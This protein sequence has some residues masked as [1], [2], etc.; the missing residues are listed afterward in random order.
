MSVITSLL[1][2]SV[3]WTQSGTTTAPASVTYEEVARLI[4]D[5]NHPQLS[6]REAAV[7]R[8]TELGDAAVAP[9]EKALPN[10]PTEAQIT[11]TQILTN[12]K[13]SRRGALVVLVIPDGQAW[14]AGVK[15]GDVFLAV[16]GKA[17][18]NIEAWSKAEE[19]RSRFQAR[20]VLIRR[21]GRILNQKFEPGKYGIHWCEY[22]AGWGDHLAEAVRKHNAG[23]YAAAVVAIDQAIKA[24]QQVGVD[25]EKTR[26]VLGLIARCRYYARPPAERPAYLDY[27]LN[28]P[29]IRSDWAPS[30]TS[31]CT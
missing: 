30:S 20:T 9:L 3:L 13:Q 4:R 8:L 22:E 25:V 12:I 15:P 11:I 7:E 14:Y 2:A 31:P 23:D 29:H 10:Q 17:I 6:R 5:L 26:G 1:L 27:L 19:A 24:G 28:T 18:D 16:D 21:G